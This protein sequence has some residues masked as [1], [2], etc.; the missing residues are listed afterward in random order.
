M[1]ARVR[2]LIEVASSDLR[3]GAVNDA[4][5]LAEL[6]RKFGATFILCGRVDPTLTQF[7][8]QRGIQVLNAASRPLSKRGILPYVASV[9]AWLVR[10]RRIRPDVVHLN[11]AAYAPS[12]AYAARLLHIPI[13]S[14]ASEYHPANRLNRWAGAYVANG[15]AHARSLLNSPLAARVRVAGDLFR[16]G[17]L[18]ETVAERPLP[19]RTGR[20]RYLFLGQLVARKGIETLLH[21][22]AL[23]DADADL[24]LAGGNWD[25]DP[26]AQ[27][28]RQDI[29]ALGLAGRVHCE[30]HRRDIAVMLHDCDVFVL[31]SLSEARP[32]VLIEAMC[33]GKPIVASNVGGIPE[34]IRDGVTGYLVPPGEP[35]ALADALAALAESPQL[36]AELGQRARDYALR[37]FDPLKTVARYVDVYREL[38]TNH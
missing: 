38:S 17:R 32:R 28:L 37:A 24:V 33:V 16:P 6:G 13:V 30:N 29:T 26:Y 10:L 23:L 19:H 15:E 2:V 21:A 18:S 11:Y 9:T 3:V 14:R 5:D 25:A 22:F 34:M 12:M 36:R 27:Q 1:A 20:L 4:V 31:P 7:A 8:E 35:K